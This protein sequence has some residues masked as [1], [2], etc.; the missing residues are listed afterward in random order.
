MRLINADVLQEE[1]ENFFLV[2]TGN[3]KQATVVRECKR[4]FARMIDEQ[5][6]AYDTDKVIEN[7]S[8]QKSGLTEWEED[9]AYEIGMEKAIEI[10]KTGGIQKERK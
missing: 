8:M 6:T 9:K 1:L 2:I 10:V 7:L 3:P 5:P 4:S